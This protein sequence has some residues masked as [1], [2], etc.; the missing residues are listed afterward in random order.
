MITLGVLSF[1]QPTPY[2][3]KI[4]EHAANNEV[5]ICIISPSQL[6][7]SSSIVSGLLYASNK[8]EWENTSF[9]IPSF[10]YDRCYYGNKNTI[11]SKYHIEA[12]KM[13]DDVHFLGYGLPDKWEVYKVLSSL[14]D[15]KSYFPLTRK[16][17][18][19]A[20]FL[21][22]FNYND[23]WLI[24]P[25]KGSQGRGLI[26]VE[27][28]NGQYVV[29]EVVQPG[30]QLFVFR[31]DAKLKQWL[32]TK[33]KS[34]EYIFQPF[35]P[36]QNKKGVPFDL[37][38]LLQKNEEG[39]WT[40]RVRVIRTGPKNYITS[41]LAG[42]GEMLPFSVLFQGMTS[43]KKKKMEENLQKIADFLPPAIEQTIKPLFEL[44]IDIGVDRDHNLWILDINSK[45]GHKIVTMASPSVQKEIYEAPSKYCMYLATIK[46]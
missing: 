6:T 23:T 1:S 29:K 32:H 39:D 10:I 38:L 22:H 7:G 5:M 33:M 13:R 40:E 20:F 3:T 30:E 8:K 21:S 41:N 15:L 4:A 27:K 45:P 44:G 17:T 42:G 31:S 9:P 18:S 36:L 16:L 28:L 46:R 26:K 24:K 34:N 11:F 12:L 43:T 25:I 19:V 2:L 35:L 14:S 37:R